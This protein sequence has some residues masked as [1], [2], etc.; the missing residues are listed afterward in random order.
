[1]DRIPFGVRRLDAIVNGGVPTGS[2]VLL[3]GEA[4]AGSREFLHTSALVNALGSVGDDLYDRYYGAPAAAAV[5][6]EAV[7]YVSLTASVEELATEMRLEMVD[8]LVDRGIDVARFHDLS[9]RYF[10]VSPVPRAWYAD[11]ATTIADLRRRNEREDLLAALG[12][13]LSDIAPENLVAIDSL[14]DLVSADDEVAAW[15]DVNYLVGGLKKAAHEWG[16]LILVHLNHETLSSTRL[17]QLSEAVD[18][19]MRFEW[20]SGGS[21]RA[22]TLVVEQFR[23][24]LSQ[25]EAEDIVRFE[26]AVG[27]AGFDISDVRKIR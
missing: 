23:G 8:E 24:V 3:S 12:A 18:G 9:E 15:S 26:T 21:S 17:G 6:P 5:Q 25:I 19:T 16:G 14:S 7:H 13:L 22:R 20:E 2:V 4:G 27:D 1:M 10:N 11:G